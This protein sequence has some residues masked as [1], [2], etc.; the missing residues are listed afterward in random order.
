[1]RSFVKKLSI[2]EVLFMVASIALLIVALIPIYR[3]A[4]YGCP[5]YDDYHYS[6]YVKKFYIQYGFGGIFKGIWY[7]VKMKW[8]IWQGTYSSIAFMSLTPSAFGEQYYFIGLWIILSVFSVSTFIL[9]YRSARIFTDCK[10]S[11][12]CSFACLTVV[13]LIELINTAHQGIFWYNGAIHYTLM[14]AFM[15]LMVV[16]ALELLTRE[17]K[18]ATIIYAILFAVL[19]FI[20]AGGNFAVILQGVLLLLLIEFLAII[21]KNK[22]FIS[23][24]P[25]ILVYLVGMGFNMFAPGNKVR[26]AHYDSF[27]PVK[28]IL[29]SFKSAF[30]NIPKYT[31]LITI[32]VL[33]VFAPI[34]WNLACDSKHK[35][36]LPLLITILSFCFY[37]TGYTPSYYGMGFE[38][39]E[40]TFNDI[41]FTFQL[42]LLFNVYYWMGWFLR[43]REAKG[44]EKQEIK[45]NILYYA[46]CI[47]LAGVVFIT[48]KNQAG[49]FSSYGAWYYVHTGEAANYRAE[50]LQRLA[51]IEEAGPGADVEL[52]PH[53]FRPWLLCGND[54]ITEEPTANVNYETAFYFDLNSI[55]LKSK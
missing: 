26:A 31:G 33:L 15:E 43:R 20:V 54:D 13:F 37:A 42:L 50:H 27:S 39:L 25:G 1:M 44:K 22:R 7:T 23:L 6:N 18:S 19:C 32:V 3:L 14:Y 24:I 49:S 16:A 4:T 35:F 2:G 53:A 36:R 30:L 46:C 12:A 55:K 21:N 29:Y 5:F 9:A 38:G 47:A 8:Y 10:K 11:R 34:L 40:R 52:P 45:Y 28:S 41:K 48:S 51:I 17:K